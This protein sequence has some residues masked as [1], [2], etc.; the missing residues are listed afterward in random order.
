MA[1]FDPDAYLAKKQG[2]DPDAY[3]AKFEADAPAKSDGYDLPRALGRGVLNTAAGALRG[4]GS[5]GATILAPYD[6]AMDAINGDRG[7]NLSSLITGKELPTRNQ[8][9]RQT[10]TDVLGGMGADTEGFAFGAGKLGGEIAGTAGIGGVFANGARALGAAPSVVQALTSGGMTTGAK[11]APGAANLLGDL[12]IRSGAGAVVGGASA[13]AVNPTDAGM[14]AA[15][16]GTLPLV[17]PVA[18]VIGWAGKKALGTTTG[19][20]DTAIGEAFRAG[21]TG[22]ETA[23]AFTQNMRGN[24]PMEDVISIAKQNIAEMGRQKSAAYKAGMGGVKSD[25]TVLDIVNIAKSADDA[26]QMSMYKGQVKD[27][28]ASKVLQS[29]RDSVDE[30][31]KLDPAEFHTPEGLDALKQR[32]GG[33]LEAIPF[34]QKTAR[35]AAGNV[36]NAIKSEITKQAPEYAKTMK[37]YSEASALIKEAERALSLGQKASADTTLRKLQSLMR[38]NVNTSYGY[39][40]DLA[41]QMEQMG[42]QEMLPA[43]AG[44]ALN[45]WMPRGIQ[46]A[47]T[48]G[49]G[50]ALLFTGNAPAA[51]GLAAVSSPRLA[52]ESAYLAGKMAQDN[53]FTSGVRQGVYRAAPVAAP[54]FLR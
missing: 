35:S 20:G 44:Q 10:M 51:A 31:R 5:I 4:A 34:E 23:N 26:L 13:A 25:K 33:I 2:F 11:V 7:K 43:L 39:R 40:A 9:R 52:G 8:E 15:V 22:G 24:V 46:R 45:D 32:V 30:W 17:A 21:K 14:G 37:E 27:E 18:K 53:A 16:G 3:L 50:A 54:N 19:A 47:A 49:G 38:N 29:I 48:G 36:Y 42:G 12:A 6:M 1:T 28:S 41:K